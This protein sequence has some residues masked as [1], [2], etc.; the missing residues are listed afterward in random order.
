MDE[1]ERS[2]SASGSDKETLTE[3]EEVFDDIGGGSDENGENESKTDELKPLGKSKNKRTWKQVEINYNFVNVRGGFNKKYESAPSIPFRM[4]NEKYQFL[5]LSKNQPWFLRGVAGCGARKGELR[6][7]DVFQAIRNR[8]N[9]AAKT[10]LNAHR[11]DDIEAAVA[12]VSE[13]KA[14]DDDPM[15]AL[16]AVVATTTKPK[17]KPKRKPKA[18]AKAKAR[19]RVQTFKIPKHPAC[20]GWDQ[21]APEGLVDIHV[22]KKATRDKKTT[23]GDEEACGN[24]T[25]LYLRADNVNWLLSYAADELMFQGVRRSDAAHE[26]EDEVGCNSEVSGLNL[27]W[28]FATKSWTGTF[29][30]GDHVGTTKHFSS[31][32]LTKEHLQKVKEM[33][34]STVKNAKQGSEKLITLWCQA[35]VDNTA[36]DFETEWRLAREFETPSKKRRYKRFNRSHASI[37]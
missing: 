18:A 20:T 12:E 21:E 5:Q 16:D 24:A 4:G 37:P 25:G 13:E 9:N 31:K 34:G 23:R 11:L 14:D 22:Y 7:V 32:Q 36:D 29:V 26:N 8:Y 1:S 10:D 3:N 6:A 28:D 30:S 27:N 15:S 19:S 35:V 2:S 17:P 33:F